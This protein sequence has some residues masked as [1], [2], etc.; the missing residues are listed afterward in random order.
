MQTLALVVFILVGTA[1]IAALSVTL[2]LAL[3]Q[4]LWDGAARHG[5][6]S[7]LGVRNPP[8]GKTAGHAPAA[9]PGRLLGQTV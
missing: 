3:P 4:L 1:L 6:F 9:G 5:R 7:G 8:S 2:Y